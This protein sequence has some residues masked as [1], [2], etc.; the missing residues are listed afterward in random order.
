M[1]MVKKK[2]PVVYMNSMNTVLQQEV[3]RF[4]KLVGLVKKSLTT[5]IDALDGLVAMNQ[6]LNLLFEALFDN[7]IPGVWLKNSYSSLKPLGSYILDL[8]KRINFITK[9]IDEGAPKTFW[10]SGFYFP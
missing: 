4:N 9:W 3:L 8:I 5:L 6:D 7:R 1:K 10:I 2:H